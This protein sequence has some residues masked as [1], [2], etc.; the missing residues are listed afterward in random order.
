MLNS[1][2]MVKVQTM[3]SND[4]LSTFGLKP[5]EFITIHEYYK[6]YQRVMSYDTY[7]N[8]IVCACGKITNKHDRSRHLKSAYHLKR[9]T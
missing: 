4:A 1:A 8:K 9:T 7:N 6:L 3:P 5:E 2:K